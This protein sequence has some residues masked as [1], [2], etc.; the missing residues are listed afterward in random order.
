MPRHS[1][2]RGR[3]DGIPEHRGEAAET[4]VAGVP[5]MSFVRG[6]RQWP[7]TVCSCYSTLDEG[8]MPRSGDFAGRR[9]MAPQNPPIART[10]RS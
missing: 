10:S 8:A 9:A 2:A 4:S 1:D 6:V 3:R 7:L 5:L